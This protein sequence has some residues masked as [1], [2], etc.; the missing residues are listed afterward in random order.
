VAPLD[1]GLPGASQQLWDLTEQQGLKI[2][3]L[4]NNAGVG[5]YGDHIALDPPTVASMLQLNILSLSELCQRYGRAMA[6]SG[7]GWILNIASTAAYQPTP[8][9]PPMGPRKS[10]C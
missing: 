1:L 9:S 7:R 4:I 8:I 5:V 2:E 6:H 10:M 3:V